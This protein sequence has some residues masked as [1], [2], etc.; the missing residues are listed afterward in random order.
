MYATFAAIVLCGAVVLWYLFAFNQLVRARNAVDQTW[1]NIEVELQRRFDLIQSLVETAK[2]YAK[3]ESETFREVAR[4][5]TRER[6]FADAGT[7]NTAQHDLSGAVA[8]IMLL[9]ESYPE[10]R[11]DKNFLQLQNELTETENRIATRRNAYNQT[12]NYYQNLCQ[13]IPTNLVAAIQ[14]MPPKAFFD[15][16][17]ELAQAP[18]IR[19]S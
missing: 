11:A 2:G 13:A 18:E 14:E 6:P 15:A 16:P 5:R 17:D 10:L 4:L 1:S 19:L 3:H 12:V 7:A 8:R 9:A